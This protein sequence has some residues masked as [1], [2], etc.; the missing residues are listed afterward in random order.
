MRA[1]ER[2]GLLEA[3]E[4]TGRRQDRKAIWRCRCEFGAEVEVRSTSLRT[5]GVRS[6]GNHRGEDLGRQRLGMVL[7]VYKSSAK[8]RGLVWALSDQEFIDLVSQPCFYCGKPANVPAGATLD[9]L[10]EP[11]GIDRWDNDRGYEPGAQTVAC[12]A[13]CNQAR[14][15]Q[16]PEGF[17]AR[18]LAISYRFANLLTKDSL[19][20]PQPT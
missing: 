19:A 2:Y 15:A 17:V 6:C 5:G 12:C 1:G 3:I 20:V 18:C 14:G 9:S 13:S 10:A 11:N 4:D 7:A 16:T 8:K